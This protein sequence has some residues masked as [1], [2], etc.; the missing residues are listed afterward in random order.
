MV[1]DTTSVVSLTRELFGRIADGVAEL[2]DIKA[3]RIEYY[4]NHQKFLEKIQILLCRGV[5]IRKKRI[6]WRKIGLIRP[7]FVYFYAIS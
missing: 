1:G 5:K 7:I 4:G 2:R 6:V 3:L